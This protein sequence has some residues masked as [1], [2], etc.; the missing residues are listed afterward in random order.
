MPATPSARV[1]A[2]PSAWPQRRDWSSADTALIAIDM[3]IDFCGK[4]GYVDSMGYDIGAT[5]A[6]IAPIAAVFAAFRELGFPIVHT[7]EG[8][9]SSL[10]D[11]PD[12]KRWRSRQMGAGI[13]DPGPCGRVLVRG[14]EGWNLIPELQPALNEEIIDKPGKGSIVATDLDLLL[15]QRGIRNLVFTGITTDV[16]V[17]TTMREASDL[18][19]DCLLLSDGTAATDYGNYVATLKTTQLFGGVFGCVASATDLLAAIGKQAPAELPV[20]EVVDLGHGFSA[21]MPPRKPGKWIAQNL[22]D[23][24]VSPQQLEHRTAAD[25]YAWP[26]D[27][28]LRTE[29]TALVLID[30][31][32]D[33]IESEGYLARHY[34]DSTSSISAALTAAAK[35]RDCMRK[36]GFKIVYTREGYAADLSDCPLRRRSQVPDG[37][38]AGG[39]VG[40]AG[41][42]GR[43][44]IR[45]SAGWDI[46]AQV[47]PC[48]S[49]L[50][51]DKVGS[52][53]FS[54]TTLDN[55]LRA[56]GI[57]NLLLA[58]VSTE[59]EVHTTLRQANDR[60]YECLLLSDCTASVLPDLHF[61]ALKQVKMQGGVF[62]AVATSADFQVALN[63]IQAESDGHASKKLKT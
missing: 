7:R 33:K 32:R 11:C 60:G 6:P 42:L 47:A 46:A 15:R 44:M 37:D 50:V 4:G 41:S 2:R 61:S 3:Q 20:T 31:Q 1:A 5:R 56:R 45:G 9:R 25:P 28:D 30:F 21:R 17:S 40:E 54:N 43:Y 23:A 51:V 57:R 39:Y 24:C 62:G 48:E 59:V 10:A 14:E 55:L 38:H 53:A 12:N 22:Q 52:G 63:N 35:L 36:A 8:H 18:G 19:Y 16:C 58:G 49:D 29:N 26:Y 13:G 34:P 27:G